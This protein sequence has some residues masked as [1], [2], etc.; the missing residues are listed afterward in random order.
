MGV[1]EKSEGTY[2][3][4]STWCSGLFSCCKQLQ[5]YKL[6]I[7]AH[8]SLHMII[9]MTRAYSAWIYYSHYPPLFPEWQKGT[10]WCKIVTELL[11]QLAVSPYTFKGWWLNFTIINCF[12]VEWKKGR[13]AQFSNSYDGTDT[14]QKADL[15]VRGKSK[16]CEQLVWWEGLNINSVKETYAT[17]LSD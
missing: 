13:A 3:L 1:A 14:K 2:A 16:C 11:W 5:L 8:T 15:L 7:G 17:C 10:T 12:T 4:Q 9:K 6:H